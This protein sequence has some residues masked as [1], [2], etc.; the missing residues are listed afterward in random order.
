MFVLHRHLN[1]H[2][3]IAFVDAYRATLIGWY[4]DQLLCESYR[5]NQ[6]QQQSDAWCRITLRSS[7]LLKII[8]IWLN[9]GF[10]AEDVGFPVSSFSMRGTGIS[11]YNGRLP[12]TNP[13]FHLQLSYMYTPCIY[14]TTHKLAWLEVSWTVA[15]ENLRKGECLQVPQPCRPYCLLRRCWLILGLRLLCWVLNSLAWN[16]GGLGDVGG[17]N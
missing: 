1:R 3:R 13:I 9:W 6:H 15:V 10:P 8:V 17:F 11:Q 12:A 4:N 16:W 5:R 14:E 7:Y 2:S